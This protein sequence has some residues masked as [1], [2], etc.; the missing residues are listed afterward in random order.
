MAAAITSTGQ[1]NPANSAAEFVKRAAREGAPCTNAPN[2]MWVLHGA[3]F[4]RLPQKTN[5]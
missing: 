1:Q 5:L 4:R 2:A 3:L